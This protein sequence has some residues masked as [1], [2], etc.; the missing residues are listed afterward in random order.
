MS[1]AC[2]ASVIA[3]PI[4]MCWTGPTRRGGVLQWG[5]VEADIGRPDL[6]PGVVTLQ[7]GWLPP[8]EDADAAPATE[9]NSSIQLLLTSDRQCLAL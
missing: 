4:A 3:T 1:I 5:D 9:V 2:D 6:P 7:E 8:D